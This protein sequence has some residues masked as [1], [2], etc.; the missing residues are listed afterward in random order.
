MTG[1][2]DGPRR[3]LRRGDVHRG[4]LRAI[5]RQVD[6]DPGASK[7]AAAA[8]AAHDVLAAIYPDQA[9][10]IQALLDTSLGAV[11]DG[12]AKDAGIAVG[13]AA[14]AQM[15]AA[16]EGDGRGGNTP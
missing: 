15:L 9:A 14:A 12:P 5:P 11:A 7:V 3:D 6:A 13:K 10:D 4:W 16:R 2:G 1:F 8:T